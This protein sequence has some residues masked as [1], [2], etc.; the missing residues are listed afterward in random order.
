MP[1]TTSD[2]LQGLARQI[3]E[4]VEAAQNS[5]ATVLRPP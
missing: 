2:D 1:D 4:A 3:R 5:V